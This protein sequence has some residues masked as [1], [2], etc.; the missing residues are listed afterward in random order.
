MTKVTDTESKQDLLIEMNNLHVKINSMNE[1]LSALVPTANAIHLEQRWWDIVTGIVNNTNYS[2]MPG[3]VMGFAQDLVNNLRS[4]LNK[5]HIPNYMSIN[6][7]NIDLW[8]QDKVTLLY[9]LTRLAPLLD[10]SVRAERILTVGPL[11]TNI[12]NPITVK[13]GL[14]QPVTIS[15]T[16]HAGA[17][18]MPQFLDFNKLYNIFRA[19][20]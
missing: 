3:M 11:G 18:K 10:I 1:I 14:F 8:V 15:M 17:D 2:V 9:M 6:P 20:S 19:D 12:E 16:L 7:F 13:I 5:T 4:V